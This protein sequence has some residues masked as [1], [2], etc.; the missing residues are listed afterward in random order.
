MVEKHV[1]VLRDYLRRKWGEVIECPGRKC[2]VFHYPNE[3]NPWTVCV[4]C[5]YP[6][7]KWAFHLAATFVHASSFDRN[8]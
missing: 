6:V 8:E 1:E 4:S 5:G 2:N 7:G 3:L